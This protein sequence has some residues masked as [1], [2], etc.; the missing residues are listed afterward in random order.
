MGKTRFKKSMVYGLGL[1]VLDASGNETTVVGTDGTLYHK[2][3]EIAATATEM[4][5]VLK[6]A[7]VKFTEEGAGDYVGT[8]S[9]PAGSILVDIIV[10]AIAL[11]TAGTNATLKVGDYDAA[12]DPIDDDGFFTGVDLKDTDLLAGESINFT[13]DGG[14]SGTDFDTASGAGAHVRRRYLAAARSIVGEVTATGADSD[15]GE[16][17][18][19]VVWLEPSASAA[20]FTEED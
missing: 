6:T 4:N 12:G 13:H 1:G 14:Q 8:V 19:T 10:H 11:W 17:L 2:G 15:A 3:V 9:L 18:M 20:V 7:T 16:T 5:Q